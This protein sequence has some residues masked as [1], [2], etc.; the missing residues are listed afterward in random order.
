MA[1]HSK[2]VITLSAGDGV[3]SRDSQYSGRR[4]RSAEDDF[5]WQFQ[6][7]ESA[8]SY[9]GRDFDRVNVEG[10]T[11]RDVIGPKVTS[12]F[13]FSCELQTAPVPSASTDAAVKM[14]LQLPGLCS[15]R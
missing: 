10:G 6:R 9:L 5:D 3:G 14:S 12:T 13:W 11:C 7:H 15:I 8:V 4:V 1:R 2:L